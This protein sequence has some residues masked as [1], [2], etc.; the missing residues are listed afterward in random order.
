MKLKP[1][2][3]I[4]AVLISSLACTSVFARQVTEP[5]LR[6]EETKSS[7][8]LAA[9]AQDK[10]APNTKLK[11][12]MEKLLADAK[13]GKVAPRPQQL[14]NGGRHNLGTAAKIGIVAA[15]AG[16]IFAIVAIHQINDD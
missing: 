15:I 11:G 4:I 10:A 7:P 1:A 16:I 6:D 9:A 13:A 3:L 8:E 5:R 2:S 14:P 12:D